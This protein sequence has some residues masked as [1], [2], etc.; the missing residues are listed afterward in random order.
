MWNAGRVGFISFSWDRIAGRICAALEFWFL[1][2]VMLVTE[3]DKIIFAV[4]LHPVFYPHP[5]LYCCWVGQVVSVTGLLLRFAGWISVSCIWDPWKTATAGDTSCG[6]LSKSCFCATS[7]E[8]ISK[9]WYGCT[10]YI[11]IPLTYTAHLFIHLVGIS[12]VGSYLSPCLMSGPRS[13]P[14]F[15]PWNCV[16]G[17]WPFSW[18]PEAEREDR[19]QGDLQ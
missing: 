17:N 8:H 12:H 16:W 2:V 14:V 18:D 15:P 4:T 7:I 1:L 3:Q 5:P 10:F 6:S 19:L 13:G 9:S 11:R